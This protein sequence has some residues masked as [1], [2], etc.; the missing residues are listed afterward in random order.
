TTLTSPAATGNQWYKDGNPI[1]DANQQT[2]I[3]TESG[4]YTLVV[5]LNNCASLVSDAVI[6]IAHP[7][8]ATPEITVSQKEFCEGSSTMLTSPEAT[9]N[10]WYK[11]GNPIQDA[12]QQTYI[13]TESGKY[14]LVVTLNNCASLVSDAVILIAHPIPATPEIT[15]SQKE[16]CEGSSTTLTSP[17]ATG[18]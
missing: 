15:V 11:D 8:P 9:G 6:L 17:A 5:T 13:A 18:N 1:Q 12:N 2:Y 4:K 16:F 14:T 7:I 10:Q 3:A